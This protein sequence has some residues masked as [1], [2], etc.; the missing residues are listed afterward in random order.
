MKNHY[1]VMVIGGGPVGSYTAHQLVQ[2]GFNVCVVEQKS[3]I[4]NG[5]VC[6]G[7]IS[8]ESFEHYKLPP[9]SIQTRITSFLFVSPKGQKLKYD[10]SDVFVYVVD[11]DLFDQKLAERA[12]RAGVRYVLGARIT[13]VEECG[14]YF[15]IPV[16]GE[17]YFAKFVVLATGVNYQLHKKFGLGGPQRF[18]YGSQVELPMHVDDTNIE[19]HIGQQY[20]PGSF[21][22]V[23][24]LSRRKA[25]VGMILGR[26]GKKYL[27]RFVEKKLRFNNCSNLMQQ[28]KIKPIAYGPVKRSVVGR[29][30]AV[31]EA[32]GQVK[33][34]TG[35]GIF[36][37]LL[38]ADIAVDKL[39]RALKK[40]VSIDDYD[41]TWRTALSSELEIGKKVRQVALQLDDHAIET[42]F[43]F[44][45]NNRFWVNL[46]TPKI[47][48]DF[49][50]DLFYY[51]LKGF[52]F[53]LKGS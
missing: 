12:H 2:N 45:K 52:S 6:T 44:I 30:I 14:R 48:F 7:V 21:A 27:Q 3:I 8:K 31:G 10:H 53:L 20:V 25:R 40:G 34:T 26:N 17:H 1:D 35:G 16:D 50:S 15:K 29:I 18:L 11:R 13:S 43:T 22:W 38:C 32:A 33:T 9:D 41:V 4:G 28:I 39:T 42:L 47:N 5:V 23:V 19:I 24:P 51:C 49:H 46:L 37:G 36:M